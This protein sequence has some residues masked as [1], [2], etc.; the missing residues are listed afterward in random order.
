MNRVTSGPLTAETALI[1]ALKAPPTPELI[2]GEVTS[3]RSSGRPSDTGP[4]CATTHRTWTRW[5]ALALTGALAVGAFGG[6]LNVGQAI[7]IGLE[8][9]A[10]AAPSNTG[11]GLRI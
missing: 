7:L 4:G 3:S 1:S 11:P 10:P 9:G 8:A 5:L 6:E 2:G